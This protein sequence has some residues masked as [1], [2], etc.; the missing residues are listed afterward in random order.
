[1]RYEISQCY[2]P[3]DKPIEQ[4][5]AQIESI[6]AAQER[7][8]AVVQWLQSSSSGPDGKVIVVLTA[9]IEF[10]GRPLVKPLDNPRSKSA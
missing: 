7:G 2:Y 3:A 9:I 4:V 10:A 5:T 1:M 6:A 8:G